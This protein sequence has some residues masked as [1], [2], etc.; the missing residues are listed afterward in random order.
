MRFSE[1]RKVAFAVLAVCV[2][3]SV[4]G[5]GGMG[6]SRE[7]GKVLTVYDRGADTSLS[8]RHSVD[9][10]LDSAAENARLMASEAGLHMDANA[11]ID[12]VAK[13]EDKLADEADINKRNEAYSQLKTA[14]DKL[15]DAA[16]NSVAEADFKNFKV[17]YDNFWENVNM[18][19]YDDY[20]K[21]AA[22]YN[23]LVKGFPGGVIAG[24]TGQGSLNTFGG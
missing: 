11:N 8:T 5:F 12:A 1:N 15:Y 20:G 19:K 14:V 13:L 6:L 17:A 3:V 2:L 22:S 9:A 10:Y 16:Y 21:L 7:R 23:D 18:I 4:I 24:I